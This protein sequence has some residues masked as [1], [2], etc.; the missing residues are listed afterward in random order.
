MLHPPL[1][2]SRNQSAGRPIPT[3]IMPNPLLHAAAWTVHYNTE[4]DS[5]RV[6]P[7]RLRLPAAIDLLVFPGGGFTDTQAIWR[8]QPTRAPLRMER[9]GAA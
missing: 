5:L 8:V 9:A 3:S 1:A 7:H 6:S 4:D 2:F